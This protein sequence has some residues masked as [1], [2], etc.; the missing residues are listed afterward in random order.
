MNIDDHI[1]A[2]AQSVLDQARNR[3]I[4]LVTAE[5]CTG[6]MIAGVL[7]ALSGSSDVVYGGFI[8]Y[9]NDAKEAMI[10]VQETTLINHGA[11]SVEVAGE[12]ASGALERSAADIAIAVTGVAGPSGGS[13]KKPVGTICFGLAYRDEV[14]TEKQ[15]FDLGE[16]HAIRMK[17]VEQALTMTLNVMSAD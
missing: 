12:M 6:G 9:A 2:L 3:N 8:T 17:T 14:L 13:A 10:G 7:T 5:S 1:L 16:R 11:V 4:K 15:V